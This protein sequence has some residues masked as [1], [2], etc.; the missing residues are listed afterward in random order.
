MIFFRKIITIATRILDSKEKHLN[1][2]LYLSVLLPEQNFNLEKI[3]K[4]H[5]I[6][7]C[8]FR[9][10]IDPCPDLSKLYGETG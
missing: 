5:P 7:P 4:T 8:H 9:I 2:N 6:H 1:F 10:W 3:Q